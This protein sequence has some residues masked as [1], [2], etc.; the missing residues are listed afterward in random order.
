LNILKNVIPEEIKIRLYRFPDQIVDLA[1]IEAFLSPISIDDFECKPS[2]YPP[3]NPRDIRCRLPNI[4]RSE[5]NICWKFAHDR[6]LLPRAA[7]IL[8]T[9]HTKIE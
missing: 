7:A 1:Q 6:I 4:H 8:A 2:N 3:E 5:N 9:L